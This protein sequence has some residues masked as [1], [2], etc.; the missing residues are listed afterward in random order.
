[1]DLYAQRLLVHRR[2]SEPQST[3]RQQ[4]RSDS[5]IRLSKFIPQVVE[6]YFRK[7]P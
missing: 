6:A 7:S 2:E 5:R 1:M 3:S 4:T